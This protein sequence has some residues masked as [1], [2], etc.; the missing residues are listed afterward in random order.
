MLR[1]QNNPIR[2]NIV[3]LV[4][5]IDAVGNRTRDFKVGDTMKTGQAKPHGYGGQQEIYNVRTLNA[6]AYNLSVIFSL[7]EVIERT[8]GASGRAHSPEISLLHQF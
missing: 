7:Y 3:K 4:L 2:D 8:S 1:S 5:Y 6:R